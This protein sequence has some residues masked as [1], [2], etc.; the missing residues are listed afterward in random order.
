[1][2]KTDMDIIKGRLDVIIRLLM[3]L[4]KQEGKKENKPDRDTHI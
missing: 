3:E 1:M 2:K 4:N